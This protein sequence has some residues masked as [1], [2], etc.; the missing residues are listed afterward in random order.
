MLN[1]MESAAK[2][3]SVLKDDLLDKFRYLI[4]CLNQSMPSSPLP[5]PPL[6]STPLHYPAVPSQRQ[7]KA[8]GVGVGC[9][10]EWAEAI[11]AARRRELIELIFY[12][13]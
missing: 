9:G 12:L 2:R 5:S 3:K 1:L 13:I 4:Y 7:P 10:G 6:P 8:V 11:V